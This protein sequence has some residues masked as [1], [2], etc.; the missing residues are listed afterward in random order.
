MKTFFAGIASLLFASL[1]A[2]AG[3]LAGP[4]TNS[5]NGHE[6]YLL[7]PSS[8]NGAE[9]EAEQLGGTLAIVKNAADER[10]IFSTFGSYGGVTNRSLWIGL[11]RDSRG[12]PFACVTGPAPAYT[13]WAPGEPDNCGGDERY[14]HLWSNASASPGHWNDAADDLSLDGS[15]PNGVVEMPGKDDRLTDP[16]RSLVGTWYLGGNREQPCYI[17]AT[18]NL[19]F[20]IRYQSMATRIFYDPGGFVFSMGGRVRAEVM[21]DKILW[22]DGTWWSRT[23]S[24]FNEG[25]ISGFG[26]G[27][28]TD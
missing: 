21:K 15:R 3:I 6:Y 27:I 22:S 24:P 20:A 8:W 14:V 16:E 13:D 5:A 26:N 19:L 4:F 25:R 11:R 12:G 2:H 9:A 18:D 28:L 10:W 7:S 1:S 23:P 17:T